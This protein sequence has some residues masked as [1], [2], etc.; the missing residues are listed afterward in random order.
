MSLED[1]RVDG[2]RAGRTLRYPDCAF[3]ETIIDLVVLQIDRASREN[4]RR[5]DVSRVENV[6]KFA[7]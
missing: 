6:A 7:E 2:R 3:E 1:R 5:D 4:D